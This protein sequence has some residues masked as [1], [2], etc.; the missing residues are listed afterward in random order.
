MSEKMS[1]EQMRLFQAY[2]TKTVE[3]KEAEEAFRAAAELEGSLDDLNKETLQEIRAVLD[4]RNYRLSGTE[5]VLLAGYIKQ[6]EGE[7]FTDTKRINI[8][9]HYHERK[10]SNT[11]KIVD[12]LEKKR[13]MEIQSDGL[14]AHKTYRLTHSGEAQAKSLM[15]QLS[16]ASSNDRLSVVE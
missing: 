4:D 12:T 13:L 8:L 5:C 3:L 10:P 9:L 15:E 1:V 16:E 6:L 2:V 14:H 11:T 7:E